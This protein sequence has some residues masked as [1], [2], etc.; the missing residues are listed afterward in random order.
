[1]EVL[2][3]Q[4]EILFF[5]RHL[6]LK[7]GISISKAFDLAIIGLENKFLIFQYKKLFSFIDSGL[8][9]SQ[10]LKRL[11]FLIL[12]CFLCLVLR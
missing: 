7:N 9:L 12:W 3:F 10:A 1:M 4:M 2:F 6:L 5:R 8:E 11:I